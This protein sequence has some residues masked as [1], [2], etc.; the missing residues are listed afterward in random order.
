MRIGA[1]QLE[2]DR[3]RRVRQGRGRTTC[4]TPTCLTLTLVD[5]FSCDM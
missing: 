3:R 4:L 2:A 5:M 1:R